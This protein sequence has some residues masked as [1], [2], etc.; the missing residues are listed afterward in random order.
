M[1]DTNGGSGA[2]GGGSLTLSLKDRNWSG[3]AI[4]R[5]GTVGGHSRA[6]QT[7]CGCKVV[8]RCKVLGFDSNFVFTSG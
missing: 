2:I 4:E 1:V 3:S 5:R 6:V 7:F 8:P